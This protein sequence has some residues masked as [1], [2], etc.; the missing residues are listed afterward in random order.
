MP[1]PDLPSPAGIE[2]SEPIRDFWRKRI[3]QT[4]A[5]TYMGVPLRK[6]PEDL[7]VYEHL[8]QR[9]SCSVVIELG[10]NMGGSALWLRDRL[11]SLAGY[12][13]IE[14]PLVVSIDRSCSEAIE[15]LDSADPSWRDSITVIE[16]DVRDPELPARVR[17][18]IPPGARCLVS[19]DTAHTYE[20]TRAAL[21]GFAEFVSI[22]SFFVVEDGCVDIEEMRLS[23]NWPRGVLPAVRDWLGGQPSFRVRRDLELYGLSCNPEGYLERVG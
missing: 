1:A 11:R 5:D 12:G 19:E 8:L 18:L 23:E 4:L 7:R 15:R 2:L 21:D 3:R 22:G 13:H 6:L 17:D 20:T 14:R 10:T 9:A 16:A